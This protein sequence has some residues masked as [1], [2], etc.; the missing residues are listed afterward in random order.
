[1]NLRST[2]DEQR[3]GSLAQRILAGEARAVARAMSL[4]EDGTEDGVDLVRAIYARTGRARIIGITGPPGAG[5]STLVDRLTAEIRREGKRVGVIAV[6]PTSPF[7]GGAV[8][9]DRV[10]MGRHHA[11]TGVFIRSM[12]TRGQLG[13]LAHATSDLA[14]ILDAA[15]TDVVIIE[16]VGVG[17]GEVDIVR[18]ADVCVVVLVPG[19][20]DEVQALKAG[21]ME[22]ADIFVVNQA[23]REGADRLVQAIA[24]NQTLRTIPATEW[25]PPIL[26]T[27]ATTGEGVPEVWASIGQ[28]LERS[29]N[30]LGA[31]QRARQA[32]R[33]RTLLFEPLGAGAAGRR[34]RAGDRPYRR[35]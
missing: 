24:A 27:T 31:R 26:K 1:M 16:T 19:S 2:D 10:R 15:G 7:S 34:N 22:I 30:V 20:G 33:L 18:T 5:K 21:I 25:R 12:A 3:S 14:L 32:Y 9:G 28:F 11:D 35:A 23:D 17:Q 6:D 29:T 4:V 8:L 13:G